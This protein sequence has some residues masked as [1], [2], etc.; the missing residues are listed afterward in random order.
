MVLQPKSEAVGRRFQAKVRFEFLPAPADKYRSAFSEGHN[1]TCEL[2]ATP[3]EEDG[4]DHLERM[5]DTPRVVR[6]WRAGSKTA[7][8]GSLKLPRANQSDL[9]GSPVRDVIEVG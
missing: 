1:H 9:L 3:T 7:P 6:L 4:Y 2:P 8:S 5:Q